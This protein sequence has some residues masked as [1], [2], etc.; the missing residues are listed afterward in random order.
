[1]AQFFGGSEVPSWINQIQSGRA[2]RSPY[3][4][5]YTQ[6]GLSAIPVYGSGRWQ[7]GTGGDA[8]T[9]LSDPATSYDVTS[10]GSPRAGQNVDNYNPAGVYQ[11]TGQYNGN[12]GIDGFTKTLGTIAKYGTAALLGGAAAG[13]LGGG[14]AAAAGAGGAGVTGLGDAGLMYAGASPAVAG[15]SG[16]AGAGGLGSLLSQLGSG[17]SSLLSSLGTKG[18]G[19][20]ASLLGGL[21]GSGGGSGGGGMG[22]LGDLLNIGAGLYGGKQQGNAANEMKQWLQS[23]QAKVDNL[24]NPGTPE[25][26]TLWDQMSRKDAAA[27]RNSQYGPRSVDLAAHIAQIKAD[28]TTRFTAGTSRAYADALNGYANRYAGLS[29][30]LGQATTGNSSSGLID[31]VKNL[32]NVGGSSG[33]MDNYSQWVGSPME[34]LFYGNGSLGD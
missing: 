25:Y 4:D 29:S 24:Y 13:A 17:G 10:S 22:G 11:G 5:Y 21:G 7:N 6:G 18:I 19:A 33:V 26:N 27:G 32:F 3:G 12:I 2:Q 15:A 30:A 34:S 8:D 31:M 1:M 28:E 23:Q 14:G 20:I 9:W 16:A